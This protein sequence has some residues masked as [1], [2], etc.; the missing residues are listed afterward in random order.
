MV[1][2]S[3]LRGFLLLYGV[4]SL[5]RWRPRSLRYQ[6]E[7]QRIEAWLADVARMLPGQA[8]LALEVA[9]A[10]QLVKGYGDTHARGW[11][12]FE[13]IMNQLSPLAGRADAASRLRAWVAAALADDSGQTLKQA[14]QQS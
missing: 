13:M 11:R 14:M 7:Q 6:V 4:A 8:E 1:R 2:T 5:R 3:S 9:R 12:H 10:Q